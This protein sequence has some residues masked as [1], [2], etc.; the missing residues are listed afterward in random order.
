MHV[1]VCYPVPEIP[2]L[3]RDPPMCIVI[4]IS[5]IFN[6]L[7]SN[8]HLSGLNISGS[9]SVYRPQRLRVLNVMKACPYGRFRVGILSQLGL[10]LPKFGRIVSPYLEMSKR[11]SC[12]SVDLSAFPFSLTPLTVT[13]LPL[14]AA[15]NF[16]STLEPY[17]K[18]FDT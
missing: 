15:A 11:P 9:W 12:D 1:F 13:L 16:K 5:P 8:S 3:T 10:I 7:A 18:L 14:C 2:K 17:P 4:A 6:I